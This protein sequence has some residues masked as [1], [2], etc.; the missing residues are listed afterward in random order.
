MAILRMI[1]M[2]ATL[3][4]CTSNHEEPCKQA[5]DHLIEVVNQEEH[6][7]TRARFVRTCVDAFD[8][9]RMRCL[10]AATTQDE[11]LSCRAGRVPPG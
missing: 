8:E 5:Y 4:G 11:A 1:V 9:T 2:A 7:A 3:T 10:M 6:E